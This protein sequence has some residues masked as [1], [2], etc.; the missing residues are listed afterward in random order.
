MRRPAKIYAENSDK[1]IELSHVKSVLYIQTHLVYKDVQL[2]E[3]MRKTERDGARDRL[4]R[5]GARDRLERDIEKE[6]EVEKEGRK[7][8]RKEETG[9]DKRGRGRV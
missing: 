2:R 4:E 5:D 3:I 9:T 1:L 8:E 7:R 6:R